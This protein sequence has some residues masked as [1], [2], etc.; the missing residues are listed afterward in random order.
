MTNTEVPSDKDV[1][2]RVTERLTVELEARLRDRTNLERERLTRFK[3]LV[4]DLAAEEPDLLAMMLDDLY[5]DLL[6]KPLNVPSKHRERSQGEGKGHK[7]GHRKKDS[8]NQN[9]KN[10][11]QDRD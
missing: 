3:P 9:E 11:P 5:H 2:T 8:D 6:H 10:Q 7:D 1:T 4:E